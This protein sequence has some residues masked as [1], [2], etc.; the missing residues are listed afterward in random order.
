MKCQHHYTQ[1][2]AL[3]QNFVHP[4][5]CDLWGPQ[6]DKCMLKK[7]CCGALSCLFLIRIR[8]KTLETH[9][10]VAQVHLSTC[11][12]LVF[13]HFFALMVKASSTYRRTGHCKHRFRRA[14]ENIWC[15]AF[16]PLVCGFGLQPPPG[17]AHVSL[18]KTKQ[19]K[20]AQVSSADV[21]PTPETPVP[22]A[23]AMEA[24][25]R[26]LLMHRKFM[27]ATSAGLPQSLAFSAFRRCGQLHCFLVI[28]FN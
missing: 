22:S 14:S 23:E 5:L 16:L 18:K 7:L 28:L 9:A 10:I 1:A 19:C 8:S 13:A 6:C 20:Q 12:L 11:C 21:E 17:Q 3:L 15:N 4:L 26:H 24:N 25:E 27:E 2:N